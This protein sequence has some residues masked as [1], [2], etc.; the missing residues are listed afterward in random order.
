MLFLPLFSPCHSTQTKLEEKAYHLGLAQ[1]AHGPH[2]SLEA[3][4]TVINQ[5]PMSFSSLLAPTGDIEPQ[6]P[7]LGGMSEGST[8]TLTN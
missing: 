8:Y 1:L 7:G 4:L 5:I 2:W 6:L 3:P